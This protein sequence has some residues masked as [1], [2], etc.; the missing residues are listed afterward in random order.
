MANPAKIPILMIGATGY[1]GGS[2][3]ACLLQHPNAATFA[4]TALVRSADKAELLKAQFGVDAVVGST[5][6]YDFVE[7]LAADAHILFSIASADDL[8]AMQ[9]MLR[10]LKK[11][12][13]TTNDIP[14]LIHT[15]GTGVLTT[16]DRGAF[17][18]ENIY[19]D[20]NVEQI[21]SL[22]S[23]AIHRNVDLTVVEADQEGYVKTYMILPSLIYGIASHPLVEAGISNPYSIG[24][25][26]L[27]NAGLERGQAGFVGKGLSMWPC[28]SIDDTAEQFIVLFDKIVSGSDEA[29]HGR[30]GFYFGENGEYTWLEL[31]QAVGE[32][33]FE[34]GFT[35]TPE[36]STFTT[37]DLVK[38]FGS[39]AIGNYLGTNS[40]CRANRSRA[41]GWQPKHSK[42][43]MLASI[44]PEV[45]AL[46]GNSAF[47]KQLKAK[48]G[49]LELVQ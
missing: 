29:G 18:T 16:D 43:D 13:T 9:A 15:S 21:E 6:D 44:K 2:V 37:E 22:P 32:A 14:I 46:A 31:A 3:L 42:N 48:F 33:L 30:E 19:D 17:A 39:G 28:V 45:A 4:I 27:I 38:Y 49:V 10:G 41:I 7:K 23:T 8:S 26:F 24:I 34:K 11:R 47:F 5:S 12:H 25:P 20:L 35:K 40:R 36:A 1:V